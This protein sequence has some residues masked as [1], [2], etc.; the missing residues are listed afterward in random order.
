[1]E[2][3][4]AAILADTEELVKCESPSAD[5]EAVARSADLVADVGA[6]H[7]GS[8]AE[9]IVIDGRTHLRWRLGDGPARVLLLCHHDTVWPLGSLETHPYTVSD[10]VM[11]GPG[12]VDMKAGIVLGL[13]ALAQ[14][15]VPGGGAPVGPGGGGRGPPPPP[16]RRR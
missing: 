9:R 12:C 4:L 10:G 6:R 15:G 8:V 11:R 14:L 13:H 1:M 16:A 3:R 2:A 5:L 7:L